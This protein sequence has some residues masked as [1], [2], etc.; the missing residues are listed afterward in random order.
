[1]AKQL[2]LKDRL[3]LYTVMAQYSRDGQSILGLLKSKAERAARKKIP[4]GDI[5]IAIGK[6]LS[7]ESIAQSLRRFIPT[8]EY[9]F[10]RTAEVRSNLA[11]TLESLV[12]I[13]KSKDD[14]RKKFR[15]ILLK[16]VMFF[17]ISIFTSSIAIYGFVPQISDIIDVSQLSGIQSLLF[18]M[19]NPFLMAAF[20]L[21]LIGVISAIIF[22]V[23]SLGS[24]TSSVVR[25]ILDKVSVIHI[26]YRD[27]SAS[28]MLVSLGA[29]LKG[30]DSINNFFSSIVKSGNGYESMFA[31]RI[32]GR[33]QD[34]HYNIAESLD[35]GFFDV[36]DIEQIYDY[37]S[38]G[39]QIIDA[40]G[41]IS[42]TALERSVE[43][44]QSILSNATW[45]YMI[46]FIFAIGAYMAVAMSAAV[47]FFTQSGLSDVL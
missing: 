18:N 19:V 6:M 7:E 1:M 9:V 42:R 33:L 47:Q 25:P 30:S 31:S 34:G 32:L 45:I 43:R 11:G 35:I 24:L 22:S 12:F 13:A 27:F 29:T 44:S 40:L 37:T 16:P 15:S 46:T 28:V 21:I 36:S 2:P 3:A 41:D 23:A 14:M 20:P 38:G 26:V 5:F 17:V 39:A 4:N 8:D 10:L